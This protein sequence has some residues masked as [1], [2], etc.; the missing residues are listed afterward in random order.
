[1]WMY[2]T[3]PHL[4]FSSPASPKESR[5]ASGSSALPRELADLL[6]EAMKEQPQRQGSDRTF[7]KLVATKQLWLGLL[8]HSS[9]TDWLTW[10]FEA[11]SLHMCSLSV[12]GHSVKK[13]NSHH[14][15]ADWSE[16]KSNHWI[17]TSVRQT[18]TW[19]PISYQTS[20]VESSRVGSNPNYYNNSES[21]SVQSSHFPSSLSVFVQS[22]VDIWIWTVTCCCV[23]ATR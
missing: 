8:M 20:A 13:L 17:T 10:I 23:V 19:K 6:R 18:R 1:M 11:I 3:F 16:T 5:L 12:P 7:S 21:E 9:L 2:L 14:K 4:T 15:V 22:T